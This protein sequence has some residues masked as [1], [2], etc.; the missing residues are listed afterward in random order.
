MTSPQPQPLWPPTTT[1]M[2]DRYERI[3]WCPAASWQLRVRQYRV[4]SDVQLGIVSLL[5]VTFK[6]RQTSEEMGR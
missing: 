3:S 4:L 1:A 2:P 6:G 5:R